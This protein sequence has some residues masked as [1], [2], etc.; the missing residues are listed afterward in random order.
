MK[1]ILISVICISVV[2][3]S[4]LSG[5][6]LAANHGNGPGT[7]SQA[8]Y[9]GQLFTIS[10]M[11]LPAKAEAATELHNPSKNIIYQS[12]QAVA[13]GFPFISVLD[14]IQ[15]DGFNPLW[16]EWQIT[17]LTIPPQQFLSDNEILAAA[18]VGKISLTDTEEMYICAVVGSKK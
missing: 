6:V 12:D 2:L 8:Y 4:V 18:A 10:F 7:Y 1:R 15:G 14:A 9:D 17:F 16:E 13:L 11:E 3:V 5:P